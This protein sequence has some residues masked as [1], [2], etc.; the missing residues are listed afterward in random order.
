MTTGLNNAKLAIQLQLP[1]RKATA[2][3]TCNVNFSNTDIQKMK[4]GILTYKVTCRLME[5]DENPDDYIFSF[6]QQLTFTGS[7]IHA[8]Q[9]VTFSTLNPI[10]SAR[11]DQDND[12]LDE[13]YAEI[14][15][16][17]MDDP[18]HPIKLTTKIIQHDFN[19]KEEAAPPPA[20]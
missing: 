14:K 13:I 11:L 16:V 1:D 20:H 17:N 12:G 10:D 19:T 2:T 8:T 15:M 18:S 5:R 3:V 6:P 9:P 4:L 7:G